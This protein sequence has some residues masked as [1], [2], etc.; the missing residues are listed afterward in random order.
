MKSNWGKGGAIGSLLTA[1][2]GGY[3]YYR[4]SEYSTIRNFRK[5]INSTV[6]FEIPNAYTE[7]PE[8]YATIRNAVKKDFNETT[9]VIGPR[10]VGKSTAVQAAFIKQKGVVLARCGKDRKADSVAKN[11]IATF[12]GHASAE[13]GDSVNH[14]GD[15]LTTIK[16][17]RHKMP[18]IILE[19]DN[20][21]ENN[22]LEYLLMVAKQIGADRNLARFVIIMSAAIG[23]L[24]IGVTFGA[25]RCKFLSVEEATETEAKQYFQ[26]TFSHT[27]FT[28]K[29]K[30]SLTELALDAGFR[31]FREMQ[32]LRVKIEDLTS[33]SS[34]KQCIEKEAEF[35]Y[36]SC[37]RSSYML[38]NKLCSEKG[39][40]K[41]KILELLERIS[42]G[43]Q[44][45]VVSFSNEV[46]INPDDFSKILH[47][48]KPHPLTIVVSG[49]CI[50][51]GSKMSAQALK[52]ALKTNASETTTG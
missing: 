35:N 16:K 8:L 52:V 20:R 2:I 43:E 38:V 37:L 24:D 31:N 45:D 47:D 19:V 14:L 6:E 13:A 29:E 18:I 32:T 44:Y 15:L 9:C 12:A 50:I 51:A 4:T 49:Q 28:E 5:I 36:K 22:D 1:G 26:T 33:L 3:I 39:A 21:W 40:K 42:E 23:S 34:I 30:S 11:I 17:G 27:K 7:R 41:D 48:I 46:G 10:G 25:L